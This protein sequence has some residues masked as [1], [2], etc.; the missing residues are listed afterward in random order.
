MK[1]DFKVYMR[2]LSYLK[3]YWTIAL[4]VVFGF[5]L[6]AATEVSVAKLLEHIINAIQEQDRSFTNLFP[7]LVV[8]LMFVRGVGLFLGGYYTSVISRNLIFNIRQEVFA[9]LMRLP[10]Q[11]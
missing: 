7:F 5:V 4:I 8:V 3:Q 10:S 9:K 11:Y 6:N 2:L 1:Q